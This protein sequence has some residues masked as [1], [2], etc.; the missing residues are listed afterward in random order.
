M[1]KPKYFRSARE[2]SVGW[3]IY[4]WKTWFITICIGKFQL[5]FERWGNGSSEQ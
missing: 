2:H 3:E 4:G 5:Q 1:N